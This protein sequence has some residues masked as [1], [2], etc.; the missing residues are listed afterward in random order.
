ML[1]Q[2]GEITG[3]GA[4]TAMQ[5]MMDTPP[6]QRHRH[7]SPQQSSRSGSWEHAER[8]SLGSR[9]EFGSSNSAVPFSKSW[10]GEVAPSLTGAPSSSA[11]S[12]E[13]GTEN[14]PSVLKGDDNTPAHSFRPKNS[15]SG[16]NESELSN[17]RAE[18]R[19]FRGRL[20]ALNSELRRMNTSADRGQGAETSG[21]ATGGSSSEKAR[22]ADRD[23][24][25][26]PN[27]PID[28]GHYWLLIGGVL[29]GTWRI[30]WGASA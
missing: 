21:G 6:V 25:D 11:R 23:V 19:Q 14:A 12:F 18:A 7:V 16:L 24:P 8:P 26:P 10:R 3:G 1:Y 20:R 2:A 28:N 4:R 9:D 17:W 15:E 5:G 13:R 29:W 22:T 30:W 27:V